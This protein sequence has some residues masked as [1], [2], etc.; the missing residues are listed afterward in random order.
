MGKN[1]RHVLITDMM[2]EVPSLSLTRLKSELGALSKEFM[3]PPME[4]LNMC[5]AL[6]TRNSHCQGPVCDSKSEPQATVLIF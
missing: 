6:R 3:Q 4:T 1:W 2:E 5:L